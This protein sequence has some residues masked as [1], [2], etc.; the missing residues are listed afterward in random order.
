MKEKYSLEVGNLLVLQSSDIDVCE[1]KG[2]S[3]IR[4]DFDLQFRDDQRVQRF[5]VILWYAIA[6]L[7]QE[8]LR[9]LTQ[10]FNVIF[11]AWVEE[12]YCKK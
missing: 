6:G 1:V 3:H 11:V 4:I 10:A 12:F 7:L 5:D 8:S 9:S 2:Q